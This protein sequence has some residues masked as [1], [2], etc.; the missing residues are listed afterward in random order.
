MRKLVKLSLLFFLIVSCQ[1]KHMEYQLRILIRN[2]TDSSMTVRVYP[3][4]EYLKTRFYCYSDIYK[5]YKDTSFVADTKLGTEI[6]ITDTLDIEPQ[7][8][9]TR[10]FDSIKIRMA[11]G[12]IL[13]FSP[14][15]VVNYP[16]NL[17]T[18]KS[19][20]HHEKNTFN[21]LKTW[22]EYDLESDDYIFV[23]S[24]NI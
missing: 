4:E 9:T 6:Y 18:D 5:L 13:I 15:K 8:L 12:K 16:Q 23:I 17:F 7:Q 19:V 1:D 14:Q 11:S 3:K 2:G 21:Q 10:V 20:W 24:N 22:R